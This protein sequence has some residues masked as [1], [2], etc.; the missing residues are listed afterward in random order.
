MEGCEVDTTRLGWL[1][2][3][4]VCAFK[5]WI[6]VELL[7]AGF[8]SFISTID[9]TAFHWI[10]LPGAAHNLRSYHTG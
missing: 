5:Y 4:G 10:R 9:I 6:V 3:P 1:R 2:K 8:A 7:I